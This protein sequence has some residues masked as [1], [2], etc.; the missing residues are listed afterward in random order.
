[1]EHLLI[2]GGRPLE[3][4][5]TADGAKNAALPACVAT[6]LTDEPVILHRVPHLR[7]VSTILA[8]VRALGKCVV[9][10]GQ[11]V[12][13]T[14]GASLKTQTQAYYVEQMR[15]SFL[16]L[17][18]LLA[19][20]GEAIVPLPGGC[21]IG[22][23]PVDIHL[24]GLRQL[25][26]IIEE[27]PDRVHVT[28]ETLRGTQIDL[29]YPSVGATEQLL[30][31]AT[32]AKGETLLK[33]PARE[34]E[35]MDLIALLQKMGAQ[36]EV[37][38]DTIRIAGVG[39]LHGAQHT[40]IPDRMEAGTYLLAAAITGGEVEV[41]N[42]VPDHLQSF[43]LILRGAEMSLS[44]GENS[45]HLSARKRPQPVEVTTAPYPGFPTDLQ[46]PLVALLSLGKGKSFVKESVF[47]HRFGYASCLN[48]MG[49]NIEIIGETAI[50]T[51]VNHLRGSDVE[52]PDIRAGAALVLA[53]LAAN[54]TTTIRRTENIDRGYAKIE[55]KLRQLGANVERLA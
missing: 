50:I 41:Q 34:P 40:V 14:C 26:A 49:A 11:T 6:L 3:G 17:G 18:P 51:G 37:S 54:G 48:R 22:P 20:L 8:I 19:R 35:V 45:I 10:E 42:V 46:P 53:G 30:M 32:L 16:V 33:N 39:H 43:L 5:V 36:I 38:P 23:R 21:T 28:A 55:A 24:Q 2:E 31:A 47:E 25:G 44:Q 27:Q 15:A 29:P 4:A 7:D 13:T 1:M 12:V 52:A 9:Y